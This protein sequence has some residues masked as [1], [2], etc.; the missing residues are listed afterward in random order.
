MPR[1]GFFVGCA[2][3]LVSMSPLVVRDSAWSQS[4]TALRVDVVGQLA[5]SATAQ[6]IAGADVA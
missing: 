1:L 3:L 5:D 4:V 6:P 2:A